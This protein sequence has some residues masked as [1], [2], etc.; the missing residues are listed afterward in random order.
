MASFN[1]F[2]GKTCYNS[3]KITLTQPYRR[4]QTAQCDDKKYFQEDMSLKPTISTMLKKLPTLLR[5]KL[6]SKNM[7]HYITL[8]YITFSYKYIRR[9]NKKKINTFEFFERISSLIACNFEKKNS[10]TKVYQYVLKNCSEKR[11]YG[12]LANGLFLKLKR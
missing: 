5:R 9:R 4:R 8:H 7:L 10:G 6:K 1:T 2:C 11:F 3:R 12:T